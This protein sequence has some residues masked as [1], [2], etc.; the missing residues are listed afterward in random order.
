MENNT[1]QKT[2][3]ITGGSGFIG[4][5]L[6]K[7]LQTQGYTV[8]ILTR[9]T[10]ANTDHNTHISMVSSLDNTDEEYDII[11]NLAGES[12]AQRWTKK[13]KECIL[14][15]RIKMTEEIIAYIQK[16]NKRPELLI[17]GSAIGI[18]GTSKN[19]IFTE[20]SPITSSDFTAHVC[21]PWEDKAL[22]A[23]AYGVRVVLLRTGIVLGQG[24]GA[25][26]KMLTPFKLGLG[27]KMGSGSQV[28]SWIDIQDL[29]GIVKFTI[30]HQDIQSSINA[31]AP[32]PVNNATFT[33]TLAHILH[34]PSF[35]TMPAFV[36][37]LI[38]GKEMPSELL[39]NGQSVSA[40]KVSLCGYK[41]SYPTL[42]ESLER[43]LKKGDK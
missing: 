22:E 29:I 42:E 20:T 3:L 21:K 30:E 27:G 7:Y 33:K 2:I 14:N 26:S 25:L 5:N 13:S 17:S 9:N 15:S 28:M 19:E 35:F 37:K 18:Y 23:E 39:V 24:G 10:Q 6:A 43:I 36:I 1:E 34:R 12:I 41:F 32:N 8:T 31:V 38:F 11:I 40:D 4:S 16:S